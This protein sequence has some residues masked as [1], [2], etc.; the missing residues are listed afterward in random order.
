MP[1]YSLSLVVRRMFLAVLHYNENS[2]RESKRG[3]DGEPLLKVAYRK[4]LGG[5]GTAR[6]VKVDATFGMSSLPLK[7]VSI[8]KGN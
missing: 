8:V 4:Y 6:P 5:K 1:R 3:R 7:V 2:E